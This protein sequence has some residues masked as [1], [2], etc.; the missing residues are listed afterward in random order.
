M[1]SKFLARTSQ[2]FLWGTL[3]CEI[4]II[5]KDLQFRLMW[6]ILANFMNILIVLK[7]SIEFWRLRFFCLL[8]FRH[9]S[10]TTLWEWPWRVLQIFFFIVHWLIFSSFFFLASSL[11]LSINVFCLACKK[12]FGKERRRKIFAN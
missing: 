9:Y 5:L 8:L 2:I 1:T 3:L 7:N 4:D 11:L 10:L 12:E 6:E